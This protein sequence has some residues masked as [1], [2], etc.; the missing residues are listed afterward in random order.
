MDT[1]TTTRTLRRDDLHR[2]LFAPS[3]RREIRVAEEESD[4]TFVADRRYA[5]SPSEQVEQKLVDLLR[6]TPIR[7]SHLQR[8]TRP[9]PR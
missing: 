9:R 4:E 8:D 6:A 5:L 3:T 7:R 2:V 1:N